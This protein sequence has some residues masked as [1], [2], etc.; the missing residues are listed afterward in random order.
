MS[1]F[2]SVVDVFGRLSNGSSSKE[3][4]SRWNFAF[5]SLTLVNEGAHSSTTLTNFELAYV[6]DGRPSKTKN[7]L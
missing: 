7:L 3:I 5:H 6:I 2:S 4:P 1:T